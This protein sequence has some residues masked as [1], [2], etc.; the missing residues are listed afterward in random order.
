[1]NINKNRTNYILSKFLQFQTPSRLSLLS[2]NL[3][4]KVLIILLYNLYFALK[5]CN[6]TQIV[7]IWLRQNCI[8]V[9]IL[10][11]EFNGQLYLISRIKLTTTKTNLLYVLS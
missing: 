3:K 6:Q 9:C 10:G 2:L 11:K 8:K 4:V 7:I 1:M 5:K